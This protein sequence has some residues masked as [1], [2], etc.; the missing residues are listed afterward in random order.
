LIKIMNPKTRSGFRHRMAMS[1]AFLLGLWILTWWVWAQAQNRASGQL[2]TRIEGVAADL[3]NPVD[4]GGA[5]GRLPFSLTID[6]IVFEN[7]QEPWLSISGLNITSAPGGLFSDRIH[8]RTVSIDRIDWR[9]M[10]VS[11]ASARGKAPPP[12][13]LIDML[14]R[15][16]LDEFRIERLV[17]A[18][19]L[20]E[21]GVAL[22]IAG[23]I[24]SPRPG[25]MLDL[26]L[27]IDQ[28]PA[29]RP[30]PK[31]LSF[32]DLSARFQKSAGADLAVET[33]L[34]VNLAETSELARFID[35]PQG[36]RLKTRLH[37]NGGFMDWR[38]H[39]DLA[40]NGICSAIGPIVLDLKQP[41][42]SGE[43]LSVVLAPE[44]VPKD[45]RPLVG[46]NRPFEVSAK[47]N[48]AKGRITVK[49]ILQDIAEH[50]LHMQ[51]TL[52]MADRLIDID[53]SLSLRTLTALTPWIGQSVT[54]S[55]EGRFRVK[56]DLSRPAINLRA[57][58]DQV[59]YAQA[60]MRRLALTA[61]LTPS[62]K[63]PQN[64][65]TYVLD[66][67][68]QIGAFFDPKGRSMLPGTLAWNVSGTV[69]SDAGFLLNQVQLTSPNDT[70]MYAGA[71]DI[72]HLRGSGEL[73]AKVKDIAPFALLMGRNWQGPLALQAT[74]RGVGQ[75]WTVSGDVQ[76][77][78]F[79]A[80]PRTFAPLSV[81]L[82]GQS[83][84]GALGGDAKVQWGS[85]KQRLT[86]ATL[87][88]VSPDVLTLSET[89]LA[90]NGLSASAETRLDLKT[91][92]LQTQAHGNLSNLD[93]IGALAGVKLSGRVAF[94]TLLNK[95]QQGNSLELTLTG[96]QI[97]T[98][99]GGAGEIDLR[100]DLNDHGGVPGGTARVNMANVGVGKYH[101]E[102]LQGNIDGD[103]TETAVSLSIQGRRP[104]PVDISVAGTYRLYDDQRQLTVSQMAGTVNRQ[105][106]TLQRQALFRQEHQ[107]W[108]IWVP[109]LTFGPLAMSASAVADLDSG[110]VEGRANLKGIALEWLNAVGGP[111]LSGTAQ[112]DVRVG[113]ALRKPVLDFRVRSD[114]IKMGL[115]DHGTLPTASSTI[116][117]RF[118][119]GRL[120][121]VFQLA[122]WHPTPTKGTLSIPAKLSLWPAHFDL[123]SDAVLDGSLEGAMAIPTIARLLPLDGHDAGGLLAARLAVAG[124]LRDPRITGTVAV[125]K[126]RYENLYSGTVLQDIDLEMRLDGR[127]LTVFRF[128]ARD[129][130][131][132]RMTLGGVLHL[133]A[134]DGYP[135]N[136][137][138]QMEKAH[139][140]NRPESTAMFDGQL[141][142]RGSLKKLLCEGAVT[143][144][145]AAYQF[146]QSPP[147][148]AI[149]LDV[150]EINA[151][152]GTTQKGVRKTA[153]PQTDP[154]DPGLN[155]ELVAKEPL[156]VRGR[157][158]ES[159]WQGSIKV[160]GSVSHP[161]I[162]GTL[163]SLRGYFDL[164]GKRFQLTEG[165]I[166]FQKAT[167]PNPYLD[168]TATAS[169][170][171][172]TG[173]LQLTGNAQTPEIEL[174][175]AEG[176]PQDEILSRLLFGQNISR[177]SALQAL[178]LANAVRI[179]TSGGGSN[180]L[181]L[182]GTLRQWLHVD[183]IDV[184]SNDA[185]DTTLQV[186]KYLTKD[187]YIDVEQ[188]IG[189]RSG[190][191]SIEVK[192]TPDLSLDT[193]LGF[194][195][196][197]GVGINWHYDY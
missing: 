104:V 22:K 34:E 37:G 189:N 117:G 127:E 46:L 88:E 2:T 175:S 83:R 133:N 49:E 50:R 5:K 174:S 167:P 79:K 153:P 98:P 159:A 86:V 118:E 172:I 126:G 158:L 67:K 115:G 191:V 144:R 124:T 116:E 31:R 109:D 152:G 122:G 166:V 1:A 112:A 55:A 132:G 35:L 120:G 146:V 40:L 25:R 91:G 162:E 157:G 66:A 18:D 143:V 54:G 44:W 30:E 197:S 154:I 16:S 101:L 28:L 9:R 169:G 90:G 131:D 81:S 180:T 177:L 70:V 84:G 89:Q 93:A 73:S 13:P 69:D 184:K 129:P 24:A 48:I 139:L 137:R 63:K 64:A 168:I 15:V 110:K 71:F 96:R 11:E 149:D 94:D 27:R 123:A 4:I 82:N 80:G 171:G 155:I 195:S 3:Q 52:D 148:A 17:V 99:W 62:G 85:G 105:P 185:G 178:Q 29:A 188:G 75:T 14:P 53:G 179:L 23:R 36:G 57:H 186:G 87:F 151:P 20:L 194:D 145:S 74:A 56:G 142:L 72:A 106:L 108:R 163:S 97:A 113:G 161:R 114:D 150:T 125:S 111:E 60:V 65:A 141:R 77:E 119:N 183:Q 42:L 26:N 170:G 176:L 173:R 51:G 78:A 38:G 103:L 8:L 7:G 61:A 192:V 107:K 130:K 100:T 164:L 59:T 43:G 33:D 10:P 140:L 134:A 165:N 196:Q 45:A 190:K 68:G 121:A 156:F 128:S 12:L 182:V 32:I 76:L 6:R 19:R 187:V 135:L 58:S 160:T 102:N 138:L 21:P 92:D 147:N 136:V 95:S 47:W 181:D 41:S 39:L 193:G